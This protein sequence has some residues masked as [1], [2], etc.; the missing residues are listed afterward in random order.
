MKYLALD[1]VSSKS[2]INSN[3]YY[4]PVR[5]RAHT[6]A[7]THTGVNQIVHPCETKVPTVSHKPSLCLHEGLRTPPLTVLQPCWPSYTPGSLPPQGLC[8][9]F[10]VVFPPEG[11]PASHPPG[12]PGR[13]YPPPTPH[14]RL[15]ELLPLPAPL[16]SIIFSSFP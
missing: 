11:W 13:A 6:C 9:C 8:T 10:L 3:P 7:N 12:L 15:A 2:S 5:P 16:Q 14:P 4:L 1:L